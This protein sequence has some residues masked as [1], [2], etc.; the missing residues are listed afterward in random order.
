MPETVASVPFA[1]ITILVFGLKVPSLFHVPL[2]PFSVSIAFDVEFKIPPLC[3]LIVEIVS[4]ANVGLFGT[5]LASGII[6]FDVEVGIT[7]LYQFDEVFQSVLV[8]PV[9]MLEV[10]VEF[11]NVN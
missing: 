5:V 6:T 11:A 7:A 1:K 2:L 8:A 9:Q 10:T 3:M 4:V